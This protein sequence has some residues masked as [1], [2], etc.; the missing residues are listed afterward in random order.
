MAGATGLDY[1]G[2]RAW[3]LDSGL[4][5]AERADVWAGIQ[6]C[7]L[8]TLGAWAERRERETA[9]QNQPLANLPARM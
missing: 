5:D 6:A 1:A 3:L 7:E 4:S 8:A 2:V 9:A